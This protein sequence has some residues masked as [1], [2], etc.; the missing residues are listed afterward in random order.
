MNPRLRGLLLALA[1]LGL[2]AGISQGAAGPSLDIGAPS[3]GQEL[4]PGFNLTIRGNVSGPDTRVFIWV[5][6]DD[7]ASYG[8]K[9][10]VAEANVSAGTYS[11][12]FSADLLARA[13]GF[14]AVVQGLGTDG[15]YSD[16]QRTGD[17]KLFGTY[18]R[19]LRCDDDRLLVGTPLWGKR[20]R[21]ILDTLI[22]NSVRPGSDDA[23]VFASVRFRVHPS[24]PTPSPLPTPP[25]APSPSPDLSAANNISASPSPPAATSEPSPTV[26]P[27]VLIVSTPEPTPPPAATPPPG[28]LPPRPS[29]TPRPPGFE[30]LLAA[31]AL[32]SALRLRRKP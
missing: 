1:L 29:P 5:F 27:P 22:A 11:K 21:E 26:A 6:D 28:P 13:T 14:I 4:P 9:C 3:A 23:E 32:G 7:G 18:D 2:S 8:G 12:T 16:G 15:K 17:G 25:P 20:G 30:F 10:R 19:N 24:A 31:G